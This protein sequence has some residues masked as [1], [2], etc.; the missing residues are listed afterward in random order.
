VFKIQ[1]SPTEDYVMD[2]NQIAKP[3]PGKVAK[4]NINP[5]LFGASILINVDEL[6]MHL[7]I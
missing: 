5:T 4:V 2:D 1:P 7:L 6:I 3:K